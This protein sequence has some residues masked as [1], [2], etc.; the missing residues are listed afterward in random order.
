MDKEKIELLFSIIGLN[1]Y[2]LKKSVYGTG[3]QQMDSERLKGLKE[4]IELLIKN[5]QNT[6]FNKKYGLFDITNWPQ[7]HIANLKHIQKANRELTK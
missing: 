2:A 7:K 6:K 4:E 1:L 5:H 3:F